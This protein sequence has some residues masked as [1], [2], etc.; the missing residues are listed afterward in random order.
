[1]A[2]TLTARGSDGMVAIHEPGAN[3]DNPLSNLNNIYFHSDLDYLRVVQSHTLLVNLAAGPGG[4]ALFSRFA[5][6]VTHGLGYVPMVLATFGSG[7]PFPGTKVIQTGSSIGSSSMLTYRTISLCA[8]A[9][10]VYLHDSGYDPV[11]VFPAWA[12]WMTILVLWN[13]SV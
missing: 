12:A 3:L 9:G 4:G 13:P 1:M 8:D 2:K 10:S 11:Y 6:L 7:D 5:R